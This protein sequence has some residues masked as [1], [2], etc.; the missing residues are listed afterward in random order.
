MFIINGDIYAKKKKCKIEKR[1]EGKS[2]KENKE[3]MQKEQENKKDENIKEKEN[4]KAEKIKQKEDKKAKKEQKKKAKKEKEP[5]K[6]IQT[7]KKKWLV[8]GTKT[9]ILVLLI[10]AV[11]IAINLGVQALDLTPLDFTQEQLYTLTDESKEKVKDI[12]KDVNIYFIG[13]SDEDSTV[14]LAKQYGKANEKINVEAIEDVSTRP[15]LSQKYGIESGTEGI[16]VEC[17]ERSKVLTSSDLVTYDT[18]TYETISIAEEKLTS[19][20]LSVTADEV[21]KVYF[22]EGYSDFSLNQNMY[23]LSVYLGNE[24]NETETLDILSVGK[25]PDDCDTLVITSPSKDFD[26]VA[27]NSILDYINRGGNILWLNA[28]IATEQ[29]F[30]NVNKI[31]ETYGIK[32]F[33]V[34]II[35]ETDTSKMVSEQPDLI[36]PEIQ[37]SDI[38][39]DIYNTT[40]VIFVNATKINVDTDNLDELN[41][42]ENDLLL[43]SEGSYFRTN[44]NNQQNEA[45]DGEE[46]GT[47]VVGAEMVKTIQEADEETGTEGI[48]SKLVIYGENYF[49]SDYQLSQNSQYGAIQL[50]YNRD[51][52]LNSIAYL[53]DREEDITARKDTGTVTYTA[54]EQQDTII[55]VIIFAVPALIIVVGIIVW[56]VR[57]RKK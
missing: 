22:L 10:I 46:T 26:D 55:R 21:P 13:Y 6:F 40:G 43:A 12:D 54:T 17:G 8:D 57:R 45:A 11:F 19:S 23:M 28:A 48:K 47:F 31:L 25:V 37:Y 39:K 9:T 7:I 4:K 49:I 3:R 14:D 36:I 18:S 51:L 42:E 27:T 1:K 33:E 32:P 15:D 29:D 24:V 30:P 35:R 34:G 56:Q 16:I 41:V 5:N 52:V 53:T 44:F 2:L 50:A 38:T 20:I